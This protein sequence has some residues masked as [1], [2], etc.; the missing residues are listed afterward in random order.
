MVL[1]NGDVL[2]TKTKGHT[3]IVVSGNPRKT[4][5]TAT[6]SVPFRVEV[7]ATELSVRKGASAKTDEVCVLKRGEVYTIIKV[8]GNWGKL[9]SGAGWIYLNYTEKVK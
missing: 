9:K 3:V 8:S 1:Y 6:Q 5:E 7:T 4:A 2:V